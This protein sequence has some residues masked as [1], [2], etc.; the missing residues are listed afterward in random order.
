[1]KSHVYLAIPLINPSIYGNAFSRAL[2][3]VSCRFYELYWKPYS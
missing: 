2:R 1:M 3:A